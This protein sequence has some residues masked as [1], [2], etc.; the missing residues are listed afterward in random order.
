MTLSKFLSKIYFPYQ[1]YEAGNCSF[2]IGLFWRIKWNNAYK[3]PTQCLAYSNHP[4]NLNP[5]LLDHK[6]R[7]HYHHVILCP[8]SHTIFYHFISLHSN[9]TAFP[10]LFRSLIWFSP[11]KCYNSQGLMADD[12]LLFHTFYSGT[13][14]PFHVVS[15]N[16]S[17]LLVTSG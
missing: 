3:A 4:I 8:Q 16:N 9:P 12:L 15:T 17:S 6:V 10:V 7:A 2:L 14:S 5:V 1:W 13:S 11:T